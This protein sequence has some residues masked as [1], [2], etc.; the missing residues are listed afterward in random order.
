MGLHLSGCGPVPL[1]FMLDVCIVVFL[2][3]FRYIFHVIPTCPPAND[4]SSKLVESVSSKALFLGLVFIRVD[5][6]R[7]LVVKSRN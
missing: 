6:L 2:V 1:G 7:V 3:H 5:F 4:E